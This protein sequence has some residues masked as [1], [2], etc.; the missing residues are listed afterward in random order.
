VAGC[1]LVEH[2]FPAQ[3]A[4]DLVARKWQVVA[5]SVHSPDSPETD[6]QREFVRRWPQSPIGA[7]LR[8]GRG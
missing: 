7:Q 2:G 3:R 1:L 8:P 5:K 6:E 4:L